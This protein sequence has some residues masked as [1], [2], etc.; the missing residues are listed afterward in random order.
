[1]EDVN[2]YEKPTASLAH[3]PPALTVR[4]GFLIVISSTLAFGLVGMMIGYA[5]GAAMPGYYRGVFS[6]GNA[7][8]FDPVQVGFGLGLSQGL[9]GGLAVGMVVVLAVSLAHWRRSGSPG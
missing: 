5:L 8:D 1:M 7:P 4:R 3:S 6:N 2:P 9:L